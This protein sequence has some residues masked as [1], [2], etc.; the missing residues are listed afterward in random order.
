VKLEGLKYIQ[1]KE[2]G[3]IWIRITILKLGKDM[4]ENIE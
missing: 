2:K 3:G 1:T 4:C